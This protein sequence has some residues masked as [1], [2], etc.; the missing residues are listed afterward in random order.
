MKSL[1]VRYYSDEIWHQDLYIIFIKEC[2]FGLI[3][4]YRENQGHIQY[5]AR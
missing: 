4:N 1:T 5:G 3:R 2:A